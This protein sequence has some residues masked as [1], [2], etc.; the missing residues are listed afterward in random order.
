MRFGARHLHY[1][2][3]WLSLLGFFGNSFCKGDIVADWDAA[4]V[5]LGAISGRYNVKFQR[6]YDNQYI[7]FPKSGD[8]KENPIDDPRCQGNSTA[9]E[10]TAVTGIEIADMSR[11]PC[12]HKAF[13]QSPH[14]EKTSATV[15]GLS[16]TPATDTPQSTSS[17]CMSY[18]FVAVLWLAVL[19]MVFV[20]QR[21][22]RRC[23]EIAYLRRAHN[24]H[25]LLEKCH[26]VRLQF[27]K[28]HD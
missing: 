21:H 9:K 16:A 8:Q 1:N 4:L 27:V 12:G 25:R 15:F 6:D 22:A 20:A 18:H 28:E 19:H 2:D 10:I 17:K 11:Q 26:E 24:N 23:Q 13:Y 7:Q 5:D 14:K 3:F